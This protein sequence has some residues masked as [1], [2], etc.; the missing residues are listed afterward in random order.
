MK[1][2]SLDRTESR[3]M[4]GRLYGTAVHPAVTVQQ[5]LSSSRHADRHN[6]AQC[7]SLYCLGMDDFSESR[8][9]THSR[10]SLIK[11]LHFGG[12]V[13]LSL[14]PLVVVVLVI[15]SAIRLLDKSRYLKRLGQF[16]SLSGGY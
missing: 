6:N 1:P 7:A 4:Y 13:V 11:C 16:C 10:P 2:V 14:H 3:R 15:P 9:P 12:C 5:D 8:Y